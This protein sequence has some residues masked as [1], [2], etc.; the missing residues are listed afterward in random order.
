MIAAIP[1]KPKPKCQAAKALK[2]AANSFHN[3]VADGDGRPTFFAFATQQK[4]ANDGDVFECADLVV[5]VWA[6]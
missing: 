2:Q 1:V 5:A 3:R 4:V 6:S